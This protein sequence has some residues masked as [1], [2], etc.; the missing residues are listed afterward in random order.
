MEIFS[1]AQPLRKVTFLGGMSNILHGT[2]ALV[3]GASSGIGEATAL[4][5]AA[6]GA[7]VALVAR[8]GDRLEALAAR[9]SGNGGRAIAIQADIT[10]D[11][12]AREAVEHTAREFGRIDTVVNNAGLMLLGQIGDADTSEWKRML[13][14]NV[15]A[16][17]QVSHAALPHL[18]RAAET[19]E[20][21]RRAR[22]RRRL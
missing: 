1:R 2:T 22:W 16:L 21:A 3:T 13:D 5:L 18:L 10:S 7:S 4:A 6:E 14:I 9:I 8:R 17:M 15:V 12:E 19:G 11:A 20:R